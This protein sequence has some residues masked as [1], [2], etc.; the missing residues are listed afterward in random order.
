MLRL[1]TSRD[2]ESLARLAALD[3]AKPPA[4]RE[5]DNSPARAGQGVPVAGAR[6]LCGALQTLSRADREETAVKTAETAPTTNTRRVATS[7]ANTLARGSSSDQARTLSIAIAGTLLVL[8]VFS[9]F[10]VT[11]GDTARSLH[12]GVASEAWALSGMS[13]GLATALLTAGALADGVGQDRKR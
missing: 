13:L 7:R 11:I 2:E 10:V 5:P 3:S 12:A 8:A 1:G 4:P 6:S 9:A